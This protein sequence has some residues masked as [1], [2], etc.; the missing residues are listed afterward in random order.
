MGPCLNICPRDP[1][2]C[3]C[4]HILHYAAISASEGLKSP[5]LDFFLTEM[6]DL[7]RPANQNNYHL[8]VT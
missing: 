3:S 4:Y 6:C 7:Q 2:T 8:Q 5:I 1:S